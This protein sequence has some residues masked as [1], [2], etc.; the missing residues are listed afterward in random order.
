MELPNCKG[1]P[2]MK[3][4]EQQTQKDEKKRRR[5]RE[6]YG[7]SAKAKHANCGHEPTILN[8]RAD[9]SPSTGTALLSIVQ[10]CPLHNELFSGLSQLFN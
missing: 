4:K 8:Q 2:M 1:Y 10:E 9:D 6:K 7:R 5:E 3:E